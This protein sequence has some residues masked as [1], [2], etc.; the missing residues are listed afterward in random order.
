MSMNIPVWQPV[1]MTANVDH[2]Y[3]TGNNI[4]DILFAG[5]TVII[6]KK[7]YLEND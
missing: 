2:L 4:L 3:L 5:T 7:V 1:L 6:S